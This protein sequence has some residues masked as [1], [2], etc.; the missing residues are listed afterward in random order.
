MNN[1]Q[2][3]TSRQIGK[4]LGKVIA[5]ANQK[6]GVG[7]TATA[8]NLGYA[9]SQKGYD[10]LLVD[11]DP[12]HNL[13]N[14]LDCVDTT[15]SLAEAFAM[16]LQGNSD[17]V[18]Q[19]IQEHSNHLQFIPTSLNLSAI[20]MQLVMANAR[21][22]VL[23]DIFDKLDVRNRYDYII[24]DCMPALN[25]L[26]I[27]A[28][29]ASDSVIVPVEAS[30]GAFEGLGQLFEYIA[31]IKQRLNRGLIVDGILF[32]K[33]PNNTL[34]YEI[35]T[36]LQEQFPNLLFKSEI[37]ELKEARVSYAERIPLADM[38]KSRLAE[39]YA[40]LAM[41]LGKKGE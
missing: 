4:K 36:K 33:V 20:D 30:Y 41:E 2:A 27:N 26:L 21:E 16:E 12:Q 10:V 14:Y 8:M 38:K 39:D 29:T 17:Y 32:T 9:L 7:K 13:T 37:K 24:L 15:L 22:F 1:N 18:E 23:T 19:L 34:S 28:L 25:I 31:K 40:N 35:R 5:I 6:G 11:L 3:T